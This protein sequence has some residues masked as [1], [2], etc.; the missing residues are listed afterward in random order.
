MTV[1]R[2]KVHYGHWLL[3]GGWALL[4]AVLWVAT[5]LPTLSDPQELA[6]WAE[7][8]GDSPMGPVWAAGA[9]LIGTWLLLPMAAMLVALTLIFEPLMSIG[10]AASASTVSAV[11]AYIAGRALFPN[12]VGGPLKSTMARFERLSAWRSVLAIV[13]LRNVPGPPY[14][15]G[16]IAVGASGMDLVPFLIGNFLGLLPGI[17]FL[18]LASAQLLETLKQT[19]WSAGAVGV[20]AVVVLL[21]L[22]AVFRKFLRRLD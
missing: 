12:G 7:Q 20:A 3:G 10:I 17:F 4:L 2:Q 6:L 11:L 16:N 8:V 21:A 13:V 19:S 1:E 5:P 14:V 15:V 9:F 22:G 18:C